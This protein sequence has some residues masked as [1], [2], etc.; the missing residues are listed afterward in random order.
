MA[1][2]TVNVG[3]VGLGR[4]ARVLTR[5]AKQSD[6]IRVVSAFSRSQEKR[7]AFERDT[8]VKTVP[9]LKTM[10]SATFPFAGSDCAAM[11][12]RVLRDLRL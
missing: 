11:A 2:R 4:W 9:D 8:G 5:A 6:K 7:D 12:D 1:A 3:I 10:L